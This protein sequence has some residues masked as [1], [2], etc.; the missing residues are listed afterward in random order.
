MGAKRKA[1]SVGT[2]GAK[3]PKEPTAPKPPAKKLTAAEKDEAK[4]KELDDAP[5]GKWP[6]AKW[7]E[8]AELQKKVMDRQEKAKLEPT[9]AEPT[10]EEAAKLVAAAEPKEGAG[11]EEKK[12]K[13][14]P[15][16]CKFDGS[17]DYEVFRRQVKV[18]LSKY[19]DVYQEQQLGAELM[20]VLSGDAIEAVFAVV[21]E[22]AEAISIIMQALDDRYGKAA[23]PKATSAVEQFASCKR[24][25]RT[26]RTFLRDY[27]ALRSK[28]QRAGKVMCPNTSGTDLLMAAELSAALHTQV[29]STIAASGKEGALRKDMPAYAAVLEQLEILAQT[30]EAQDDNKKERRAMLTSTEEDSSS[31]GKDSW[32]KGAGKGGWQK[33]GGK[34]AGKGGWQKNSGKG[35][36]YGGGKGGK[37]GKGGGKTGKGGGKAG[38]GMGSQ[39]KGKGKGEQSGLCWYIQSGEVCPYG[40]ACKFSHGQDEGNKMKRKLHHGQDE[41][42]GG[43]ARKAPRPGQ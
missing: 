20:E 17:G 29:L 28:A 14:E 37:F 32:K 10:P 36:K 12:R 26:L 31:K 8:Y 21:D 24:G 22:G 3:G 18:W 4:L 30:Y 1:G 40:D 42:D 34:G 38:K 15:P 9:F 2:G 5:K 7:K 33:F 25:K 13:L 11:V 16:K 41:E 39:G 6:M 43:P 23:M 35:G 19:P 27:T